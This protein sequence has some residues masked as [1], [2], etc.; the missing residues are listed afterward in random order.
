VR[1]KHGLHTTPRAVTVASSEKI[2]GNTVAITINESTVVA[3]NIAAKV[4]RQRLLT[5]QHTQ[6]GKVLLDRLTVE[7]GGAHALNIG[8]GD[9]AWVQILEGAATL[10]HVSGVNSATHD[11]ATESLTHAH[12]VFLPP[13]FAGALATINGVT[14]LYATVPNAARF[15]A[16]FTQSPP[17]FKIV[18]WTREP[19]LDSEHDARKRIYMV[20]PTLFGT[21]AIKGEMIIYPPGTQASNHHHEGA[22]HFMYVLKGKGTAYANESP[23]PVRKGDVIYYDDRE[24]H[25]LRSE[26]RVDMVFVEFFVPGLYK[27]IWAP[28]AAICTWTPTGR[29]VSGQKPLREIAKHSSAEAANA[30]DV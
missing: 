2:W 21:K 16:A 29:S 28:G 8:A 15:D 6:D 25:Y 12:I 20:T 1:I 27:T 18:D 7:A 23:I 10:T 24:R 3:E 5:A 17:P 9:L 14:L 11:S 22:A 30:H 19:V 26:G 4:N 13:G